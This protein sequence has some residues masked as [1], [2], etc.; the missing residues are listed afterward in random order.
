MVDSLISAGR[1]SAESQ[2]WYAV[3]LDGTLAFY[4]HWRGVDHIG[5]PIQPMVDRVKIWLAMG[6][7]VRIF[8]ARVADEVEAPA[9]R[10]AI[11]AW[12]SQHIGKPLA[13]TC[14]KDRFMLQQWDD[15]A[16]QVIPNQGIAL[17]DLLTL[18]QKLLAQNGAGHA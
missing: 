2:G 17:A 16:M 6:K 8:T 13:V 14:K 4:D 12:C 9:A 11:A 1:K 18:A 10:M 7:D 3:D 15:R 5:E